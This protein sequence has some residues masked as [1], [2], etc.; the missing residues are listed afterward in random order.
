MRD[1]R[2][3]AWYPD[4]E[5]IDY[6]PDLDWSVDRKHI[7]SL[8]YPD[9]G[10]LMQYVGLKDRHGKEIFE[11]D[12]V[13]FPDNEHGFGKSGKRLKGE[14]VWSD[15]YCGW[16]IVDDDWERRMSQFSV[17]GDITVIGNKYESQ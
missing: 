10:I 1:I 14:V 3:R 11:S 5:F 15:T 8:A 9:D 2:F 17:S 16:A 13:T 4:S 7:V 12:L 6:S